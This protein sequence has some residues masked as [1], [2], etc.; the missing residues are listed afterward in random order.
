MKD[1]V[2]IKVAC[3]WVGSTKNNQQK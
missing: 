1:R 2:Y 3:S